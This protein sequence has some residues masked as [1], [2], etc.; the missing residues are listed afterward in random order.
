MITPALEATC[1][2]AWPVDT[3]QARQVISSQGIEPTTT[4]VSSLIQLSHPALSIDVFMMYW[5]DMFAETSNACLEVAQANDH[6]FWIKC[7]SDGCHSLCQLLNIKVARAGIADAS[8]LD[9]QNCIK[10][11]MICFVVGKVQA[12][13]NYQQKP[14]HRMLNLRYQGPNM[15]LSKSNKAMSH[16][17]FLWDV[18]D[19][20]LGQIYFSLKT[21]YRM[22]HSDS[23]CRQVV[24]IIFVRGIFSKFFLCV[25]E[26]GYQCD[27]Q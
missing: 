25:P 17:H 10:I 27:S 6:G 19:R 24:G 9:L 26:G 18:A 5:I 14:K 15:F 3:R 2:P 23:W 16:G 11:E 22:H 1:K 8:L 7:S 21:R 4:H 20:F 12:C 13:L